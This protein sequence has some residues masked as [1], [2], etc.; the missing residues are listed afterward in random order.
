MSPASI[1]TKIHEALDIHRY[2]TPS[3]AFHDTFIFYDSSNPID[4]VST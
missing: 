2:L 3:V 4:I 1:A